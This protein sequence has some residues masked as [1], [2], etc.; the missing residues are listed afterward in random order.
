MALDPNDYPVRDNEN[1]VLVPTDPIRF[2]Y[3][4]MLGLD[5]TPFKQ[6]PSGGMLIGTSNEKFRDEFKNLNNWNVLQDGGMTYGVDG[7]LQ[8]SRYFYVN[9]GT[10]PGAEFIMQAKDLM[11]GF[12]LKLVVGVTSSQAI[13]NTEFHVELVEVDDDGNVI[14]DT[15]LFA[16]PAFNDARNG[17]GMV[18]DGTSQNNARYKIRAQGC[19]ELTPAAQSLGTNART[20]TGSSPN[21]VQ[22]YQLEI[23]VLTD[24]LSIT[25]RQVNNTIAGG[26]IVNRTDY[27]PNPDRKYTIRIRCKNTGTPASSTQFRIHFIRL[28]DASRVSVDFGVIGGNTAD[29]MAAPVK[30][31]SAPTTAVTLAGGTVYPIIAAAAATG[32]ALLAHKLISAATTNATSMKASAGRLATGRVANTHA[33]AW[34][35]LKFYNKASAPTVGTDVPVHTLAIPPGQSISLLDLCGNYGI[36]FA[37]GIAYAITG[38]AADNDTT[39]IGAGDVILTAQYI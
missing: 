33:T 36:S 29:L 1:T 12:P 17:V 23:M 2:T 7:L 11:L 22:P 21:F 26:S 14:N 32:I 31:L 4:K 10:T 5:G 9:T 19:S 39:A 15:E 3:A 37:T 30:V 28:V 35:Y 34:R 38:A 18:Y 6:T 13:A 25:S 16:S 24:L 27:I 20:A 8:G